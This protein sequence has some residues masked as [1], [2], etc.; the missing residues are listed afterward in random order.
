MNWPLVAFRA[1]FATV[2]IVEGEEPAGRSAVSIAR[3]T[4]KYQFGSR[5]G[6]RKTYT[7]RASR[8]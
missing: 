1:R 8:N 3:L 6:L 5:R 4:V 7:A 2:S